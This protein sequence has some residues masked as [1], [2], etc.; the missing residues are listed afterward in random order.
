MGVAD[1]VLCFSDLLLR[2]IKLHGDRPAVGMHGTQIGYAELDRASDAFAGFL[3]AH[4]I[5]RGGRVALLLANC[6]EYVIADIAIHKR[7]A[8]KI[9]L[10]DMIALEEAESSLRIAGAQALIC[11]HR[12]IALREAKLPDIRVRVCVGAEGPQHGFQTWSEALRTTPINAVTPVESSDPAVILFTGGTTGKPKGI[13]H[14]Q[15]PLG[16]CLMSHILNAEI[17]PDDILLLSTPLPHSAGWFLAAALYQ[18][19][20]VE[21]MQKFEAQEFLRTACAIGAS[22]TFAVPTMLYRVLAAMRD[23]ERTPP[24]RTIVY[25][26]APM[27]PSRLEQAGTQFGN[28]FVQ[29]YGQSECPNFITRLTKDDHTRP[30]LLRSCGRSVPFARVEIRQQPDRAAPD[31]EIGEVYVKCPYTLAGYLSSGAAIESP[32]VEHWMR[33]GDLGYVNQEGYL[34]LVDR[35]KD[36]IITGGLNVYSVEVENALRQNASVSDVAVIG[37]P[38]ADWGERVVAAIV[39][40]TPVDT[41]ALRNELRSRLASYKIPKQVVLVATLPTTRFGKVDK[42][43]LRQSVE[44]TGAQ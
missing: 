19:A 1:G 26:A 4:G 7:G 31:G 10:S 2:A 25:G 6:I 24:L 30:E 28:V 21:L 39:P 44:A 34:F 37:V 35:A 8:V 29:L 42:R 14:R 27:D 13:E 32:Y 5:G 16:A 38:D 36:M 40:R 41:E 15:G 20:R 17:Q 11:D 12:F 3:A 33:T 43:A 23:G 9:P 22:W 18:G